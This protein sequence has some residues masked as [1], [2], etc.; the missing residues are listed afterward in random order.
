MLCAAVLGYMQREKT[1]DERCQQRHC[2]EG[3]GMG[4]EEMEGL[5]L[6]LRCCGDR[7]PPV[8]EPM[9]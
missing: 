5:R 8:V 3:R 6:L 1:R 9:H 7:L 4:D 2:D